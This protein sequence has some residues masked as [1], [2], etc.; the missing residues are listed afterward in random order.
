[1]SRLASLTLLLA[2]AAAC[3]A[4]APPPTPEVSEHA[5]SGLAAQKVA[6][7]PTYAARVTPPLEWTIGRPV[8]L[9]RMLDAEIVSAFEDRGIKKGWVFPDEL[10][11]GYRRNPTYAPDPFALAEEPLRSTSLAVDARLVEPLASQVRTLVAFYQD[12]RYVLAPVELRLEGVGPRGGRGVLRV[13]VM[14]ARLSNIKWVGEIQ[15]DVVESFGPA[16]AAGIAAK[17][18]SAVSPR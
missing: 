1:M 16:I 2:L 15:G 8:E 9:Q 14:D 5:L 6:V 7:L 10:S 4:K 17:L 11:Q 18:A 13:V 3:S 12:V